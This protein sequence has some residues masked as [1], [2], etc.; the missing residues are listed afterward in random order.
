MTSAGKRITGRAG[1]GQGGSPSWGEEEWIETPDFANGMET[2]T[3]CHS[4]AR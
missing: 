2:A 3:G 4:D 1:Q